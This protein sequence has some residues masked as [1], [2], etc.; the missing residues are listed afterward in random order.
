MP[1]EDNGSQFR[2]MLE[3][4]VDVSVFNEGLRQLETAYTDF[5]NRIK[6]KGGSGSDIIAAG[7]VGALNAQLGQLVQTIGEVQKNLGAT[8]KDITGG[9]VSTL[10]SFERTIEEKFTVSSKARIKQAE[11]EADDRIAQIKKVNRALAEANA[12]ARAEQ[13]SF[14]GRKTPNAFPGAIPFNMPENGKVEPE[15]AKMAAMIEKQLNDQDKLAAAYTKSV[16]KK[17]EADARWITNYEKAHQQAI[18]QNE[19]FDAGVRESEQKQEELIAKWVNSYETAHN[20]AL[21]ENQ[22]FNTKRAEQDEQYYARQLALVEREIFL[23]DQAAATKTA[24][25]EARARLQAKID[26]DATTKQVAAAERVVQVANE[27]ERL[28]TAQYE[29][30]VNIRLA[31]AAKESNEKIAMLRREEAMNGRFGSQTQRN[32]VQALTAEQKADLGLMERIMG[33]LTK[34]TPEFVAS[35]FR[36]AAT[37]Q[38]AYTVI[39]AMTVAVMALP[40]AFQAGWEYLTKVEEQAQE[41]QGSIA[42]TVKLSENLAENFNMSAKAAE[43]IVLKFQ[44]IAA[45][46]NLKP[47]NLQAGFKAF[48]EGG[49]GATVKTLDEATRATELFALAL[50]NSGVNA[51]TTR[52]L[53]SEIPKLLNDSIT[54]SSKLLEVLHLSKDEWSKIRAEALKHHNLVELLEPRMK[55]YTA[56]TAESNMTQKDMTETAGN[57]LSR[58]EGIVAKPMWDAFNATLKDAL[59]WFKQHKNQVEAIAGSIGQFIKDFFDFVKMLA[60]ASGAT[61]LLEEGFKAIGFVLL[62]AMESV[63]LIIDGMRVLFNDIK[64]LIAFIANPKNWNSDGF[65]QFIA[66]AQ[67]N[68]TKFFDNFE[69]RALRI[70]QALTGEKFGGQDNTL[71]QPILDAQGPPDNTKN[72]GER[73]DLRAKLEKELDELKQQ[74]QSVVQQQ[75]NLIA[76][77]KVTV[78]QGVDEIVQALTKEWLGVDA[79]VKKYKDLANTIKDPNQRKAFVE[80]LENIQR[81]LHRQESKRINQGFTEAD[82]ADKAVVDEESKTRLAVLQQERQRERALIKQAVSEGRALRSEGLKAELEDLSDNIDDQNREFN[83]QLEGV[84][85][86]TEKYKQIMRQKELANQQYLTKYITYTK[87][88]LTEQDKELLN[89]KKIAEQKKVLDSQNKITDLQK[90][91]DNTG[92][93]SRRKDLEAEIARLRAQ[94]AKSLVTIAQAEYDIA[95]ARKA[96]QQVLDDLFNKIIEAK[97]AV[98]EAE[99]AADNADKRTK[100]GDAGGTDVLQGILGVSLDDFAHAFDSASEGI[101]AFAKAITGAINLIQGVMNAWSQGSASGGTLGGIG[102]VASMIGGMLPGPVGAVVGAVG[103]VFSFVG[104]LLTAAARRLAEKMKKEFDAIVKS[105]NNG[106]ITL[107]EAIKET[108]AKRQ[109]AINEL[110]GKKGGKDELKK[111]LP[112]FDDT[113]QSLQAKAKQIIEQFEQS[114]QVL[115]LNSEPMEQLLNTWRQ[116]NDQVKEYIGAGGD[117]NQANEFL[118][119]SLKKYRDSLLASLSSDEQDAIQDAIQLNDLL[120]QRNKLIDDFKKKEFDLLTAD[121]LEQ[122]QAGS[123]VRGRELTAAREE[124]QKQLDD[125][126]NQINL[127]TIK[128]EKEREVYNLATDINELH[129]RDEEL[130]LEALDLQLAKVRDIKAIIEGITENGGVF[131]L[132][133]AL[134]ARLGISH[135]TT[136]NINVTVTVSGLNGS[137]GLGDEIADA[138]NRGMRVL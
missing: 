69:K 129:R 17:M 71:N 135:N 123:V 52:S 131:G 110:S 99:N 93:L 45:K 26:G 122:R 89:A 107:M 15:A 22:K 100:T 67:A 103:S 56:V 91:A 43:A 3:V 21:I 24:A 97:N 92:I 23:A 30:Q 82:T 121:S 4:G 49:G 75:E 116:I 115:R 27:L 25:A 96:D 12:E 114:L 108:E 50:K 84:A 119:L 62:L 87:Q 88:I 10:E 73:R 83:R 36:L 70:N 126:N 59:G 127:T 42:G 40:R 58:V 117:A 47:E 66:D 64:S 77:H 46:D 113:I 90:Q 118:S 78:R 109:Q 105:Y 57:M 68:S 55:A 60:E 133:D 74:T 104:G 134:A 80:Q 1:V 32:L 41:L 106:S 6:A 101:T 76:T 28:R 7:Q 35:M 137:G 39:Q 9:V 13:A 14:D 136:N 51:Q 65:N 33:R 37:L 34:D 112:Q 2:E 120:D 138:I 11:L 38:L 72:K 98:K 18:A 128:V 31:I 48:M 79:L 130:Q 124:F 102:G 95:A 81:D 125:L 63:G 44:D 5:L 29:A 86:G 54:P 85:A 16:E 53:I 19:K 20:R 132:S 111:L 94:Q 8:L 61:F